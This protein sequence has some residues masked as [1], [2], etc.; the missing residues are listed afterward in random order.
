M[1]SIPA[2]HA[3]DRGS[4]PRLG[5]FFSQINKICL[6]FVDVV[7]EINKL[8]IF[9]LFISNDYSKKCTNIFN[10]WKKSHLEKLRSYF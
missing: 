4:I 10:N 6:F 7:D 1:V 8:E 2:C 9:I 3:G 5:V